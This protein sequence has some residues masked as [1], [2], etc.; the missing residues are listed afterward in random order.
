MPQAFA[1]TG[2]NEEPTRDE[3]RCQAYLGLARGATGLFWYALSTSD[4]TKGY[5]GRPIWY[6]PDSPLWDAFKDLNA[7]IHSLEPFLL[8]G[9]PQDPVECDSMCIRTRS[10]EH[11]GSVYVIAVNPYSE[12]VD[13]TFPKLNGKGAQLLLETRTLTDA[14]SLSDHFDPLAVHV[15]KLK[16]PVVV[17]PRKH[18]ETSDLGMGGP[19]TEPAPKGK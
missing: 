12:P 6:L 11:E 19:A 17:I 4:A 5:K 3:L 8:Q 10:W 14:K 7:E 18:V 9:K 2:A 13:C 16:P 15:Y 1:V